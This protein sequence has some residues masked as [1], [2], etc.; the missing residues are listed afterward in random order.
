M[1]VIAGVRVDVNIC[2]GVPFMF[3]ILLLFTVELRLCAFYQFVY[4]N[5]TMLCCRYLH[6]LMTWVM[7][8][9]PAL[10]VIFNNIV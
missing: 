7:T 3:V 10:R 4:Q 1:T 9:D 8:S 6:C 5:V 2:H